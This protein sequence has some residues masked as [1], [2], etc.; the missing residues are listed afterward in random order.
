MHIHIT[1]IRNNKLRGSKMHPIKINGIQQR[2]LPLLYV[3]CCFI[4]SYLAYRRTG[5]AYERWHDEARESISR[6]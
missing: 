3:S 4:S 5:N 2:T 1:G 6:S